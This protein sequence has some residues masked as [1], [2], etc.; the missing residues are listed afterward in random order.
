MGWRHYRQHR[1][2]TLD[3]AGS[4]SGDKGLRIVD[5]FFDSYCSVNQVEDRRGYKD[6]GNAEHPK[7]DP[8]SQEFMPYYLWYTAPP[9]SLASLS[10]GRI[11]IIQHGALRRVPP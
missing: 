11:M 7:C 1:L 9:S 4:I 10:I 8:V 6:D 5:F 3:L 2:C